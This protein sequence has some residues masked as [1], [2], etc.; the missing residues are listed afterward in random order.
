MGSWAV[1]FLGVIALG[2]IVQAGFLIG[3]AVSG[4]RL[5]RRLD[6]FQDRLDRDFRPTLE[7]L[8]RVSRNMAEVSDIA[9]LQVRRV[10]GLL[11]DT[12]DKIEDT[13]TVVRR[14]ILGPL[15]PIANIVAM[16]R[17]VRRGLEVFREL[18]GL[19]RAGRASRRYA[20]D[21]HLFI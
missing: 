5:A 11:E 10:D 16:L 19:E 17:G 20:E 4:R 7:H 3:L 15:G 14:V 21:E 13:T 9:V 6:E 12:I 18:R 8:A 1:V 2:S